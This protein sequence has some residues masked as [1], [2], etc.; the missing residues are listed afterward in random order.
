LSLGVFLLAL[1]SKPA[2]VMLPVVL[3]VCLWWRRGQV[4]RQDTIYCLPFFLLSF[5]AGVTTV[6]FQYSNAMHW[7]TVRD[8]DFWG[9]LAGAGWPPWFYFFKAMWPFDLKLIYPKWQID[10]GRLLSWLPGT[11]LVGCFLFLWRVRRPWSRAALFGLGY[12]V[13]TL[14]P[15]LGFFDQGFYRFSLVA[16]HWQY[17]SIV[18]AIALG[19]ATG[20]SICHKAPGG[21]TFIKAIVSVLVL[22]ALTN[23]T[24]KRARLYSDSEALWR[25][26]GLKNPSARTA[27]FDP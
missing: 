1:L 22:I 5:V 19:V 25:D 9:R 2:V 7:R 4:E 6:W 24:W 23:M 12:F 27:R 11:L 8:A 3:L 18:G 17:Y 13:V 16:D 14:F 10:P 15:V 21:G 20:E 26:T